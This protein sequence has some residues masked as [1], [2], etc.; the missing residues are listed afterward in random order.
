MTLALEAAGEA[1]ELTARGQRDVH[2]LGTKS[3]PT[4]VVTDMDRAA[5]RLLRDRLLSARPDDS[6]LGEEEGD[7][8]GGSGVRWILD[9]IDGTVNYL[10]GRQ[11]W[12]VSV[13][14]EVEG[15]VVAGV[16]HAPIRGEVYRATVGGGAFRGTEPLRARPAPPLQR[17]LLAT[18][19][20]YAAHRR[21]HQAEV[22]R[23][24]LPRVRDIRRAGA[25]T[26]DVCGV[27]VGEIDGY[28]ERG[29]NHWDWA[30]S[31]LI[32]QEAG[33]T[34]GG[35]RGRGPNE[36]LTI[37]APGALFDDLC[38]VLEPLAADSDG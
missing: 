20:G 12:A 9:P 4:D 27:A 8:R 10:Y 38:S 23:S 17:A 31:T 21:A 35:L 26:L 15:Q 30:A 24:V 28:Y 25:S 5:E 33:I 2:V 34:V 22:L 29:L 19:F 7:S 3:T 11:D 18:G 36:D 14:A 16:V 6:V 37:A 13:A 1:A 32:A